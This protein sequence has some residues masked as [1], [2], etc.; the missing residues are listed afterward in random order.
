M[1]K[2]LIFLLIWAVVA[3]IVGWIVSSAVRLP[4]PTYDWSNR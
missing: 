3:A 4:D 2:F 1:K